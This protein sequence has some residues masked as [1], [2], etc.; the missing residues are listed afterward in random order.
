MLGGFEGVG[1]GVVSGIV[2]WLFSGWMVE[3]GWLGVVGCGILVGWV[4]CGGGVWIGGLW[5]GIGGGVVMYGLVLWSLRF[6]WE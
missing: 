6:E 4:W 3:R 5:F 2:G 1:G